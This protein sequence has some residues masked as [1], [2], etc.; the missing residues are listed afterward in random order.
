MSQ[1]VTVREFLEHTVSNDIDVEY[2]NELST[3]ISKLWPRVTKEMALEMF[4]YVRRGVVV[5]WL[6]L[7][8]GDEVVEANFIKTTQNPKKPFVPRNPV[9]YEKYMEDLRIRTQ[10]HE[11][12]ERIIKTWLMAGQSTKDIVNNIHK[13]YPEVNARVLVERYKLVNDIQ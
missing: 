8:N 11:K 13:K 9:A 2:D 10:V 1:P 4:T 3:T 5:P 6:L 12:V 7:V